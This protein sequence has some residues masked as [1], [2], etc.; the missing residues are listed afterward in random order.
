MTQEDLSFLLN[1][2]T[3]HMFSVLPRDPDKPAFGDNVVIALDGKPL[4]GVTGFTYTRDA[5]NPVPEITIKLYAKLR[6]EP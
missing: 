4:A 3:L 1:P 6:S 2:E 5:S